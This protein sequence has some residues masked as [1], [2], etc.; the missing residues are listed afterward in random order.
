MKNRL[1]RLAFLLLMPLAGFGAGPATPVATYDELAATSW[2][3]VPWCGYDFVFQPYDTNW[4]NDRHKRFGVEAQRQ[5]LLT[6]VWNDPH[7]INCSQIPHLHE[8]A[9]DR[10]RERWPGKTKIECYEKCREWYLKQRQEKIAGSRRWLEL[11]PKLS[12]APFS[13]M[14]GHGW[15]THGPAGW[16]CDWLGLEVGENIIATELHVAF[17]RGAARMHG[18]P[19][20]CDVSQWHGGTTPLF[21]PGQEDEHAAYLTKEEATY[22]EKER[23]RKGGGAFLNGGHSSSLLSRLW[24]LSWLSGFTVVV[25]EGSQGCFFL[26]GE[27]ELA[28]QPNEVSFALSPIGKRAKAFHDMTRKHPDRGIPFTPVAVMLDKYAGFFG[29]Q[30]NT[31]RPWGVLEPTADDV[32]AYGFFSEL[33]PN[34]LGWRNPEPTKLTEMPYTPHGMSFDVVTDDIRNEALNPY[35]ACILIGHHEFPTE[36]MRTLENYL[37]AGGELYL[38]QHQASQLGLKYDELRRHGKVALFEDAKEKLS[39]TVGSLFAPLGER[40]MPVD[41]SGGRIEYTVSR[42]KAGWVIGLINNDG[43]AKGNLTPVRLDPSCAKRIT[44]TLKKGMIGSASEW[45]TEGKLEVQANSVTLEVPAGEVRI[46]ELSL[47]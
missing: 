20:F 2:K 12:A 34:S 40:H 24:Y 13:A 35:P 1:A 26:G 3:L 18:L 6:P 32:S 4:G 29:F 27:K 37:R 7:Y 44:V 16:G 10:L 41:V 21:L 25:P 46:V 11:Y 14:D 31:M 45:N 19:T 39:F 23:I 8:W 17:L 5:G 36:T 42:N 28:K 38:T 33:V 30:Q 9:W 15:V 47:K 43:V 22:I